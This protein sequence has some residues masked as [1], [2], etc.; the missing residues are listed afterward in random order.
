M[1]L[2]DAWEFGS[3]RCYMSHVVVGSSAKT[4]HKMENFQLPAP[5]SLSLS[6]PLLYLPPAHANLNHH[7]PATAVHW[8]LL[9]SD[10]DRHGT[11]RARTH[12]YANSR[13]HIAFLTLHLS[14]SSTPTALVPLYVV[15]RVHLSNAP[16][17]LSSSL[18]PLAVWAEGT[19]R[20]RTP[21]PSVHS[22][23]SVTQAI[24]LEPAA[25]FPPTVTSERRNLVTTV[26]GIAAG[27]QDRLLRVGGGA[28]T[29][30]C[31]HKKQRR[32]LWPVGWCVS[33]ISAGELNVRLALCFLF[34]VTLMCHEP[35]L[36]YLLSVSFLVLFSAMCMTCHFRF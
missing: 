26:G 35:G 8:F 3:V 6:H 19:L 24:S 11:T 25:I 28:H 12:T 27:W 10:L 34:S 13:D 7:P 18:P 31:L 1:V 9:L 5:I 33:G 23:C 20:V 14:L 2:L 22:S 21:A 17:C 30:K 16:L 32:R 29:E 15:S 36:W 4:S